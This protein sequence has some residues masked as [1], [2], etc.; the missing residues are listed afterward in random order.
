M[1]VAEGTAKGFGAFRFLVEVMNEFVVQLSVILLSALL[2]GLLSHKLKQPLIVGYLVIGVVLGN[3]LPGSFK[4]SELI[5]FLGELGVAFLLFSLGL[6]FSLK[7]ISV[8]GRT[9]FFGAIL[10]ILLTALLGFFLFP[11]LIGVGSTESIFLAFL[12]AF[13]STA[14]VAKILAEKGALDSLYGELLMGWLVTQDLA[15]LPIMALI[16]LLSGGDVNFKVVAVAVLKPILILYTVLFV[17]KRVLPKMFVKLALLHSRELMVLLGVVFCVVFSYGAYLAGLPFALG[18]FLA[19]VSLSAS[20]INDEV[21]S[22]IKS[23]RDVFAAIFFV[24]LGFLMSI[25][26]LYS[27]ALKIFSLSLVIIL[28]KFAIVFALALY[29]RYHSK[30]AFLVGVGLVQIGEFSFLLGKIGYDTGIMSQASFQ[31]IVSV[32]VITI[33]A[34]PFLLNKAEDFY[35]GIRK[36]SKKRLPRVYNILFVRFDDSLAYAPKRDLKGM[37]NHV[38]LVGYGRVGRSVARA[39]DFSDHKYIVVDLSYGA[40]RFLRNRGVPN[41]FGDA[42]DAEV[43]E[44]ANIGKAAVLILAKPGRHE[45]EYIIRLAR[46]INPNVKVIVRAHSEEEAASFVV[47]GVKFVVEPEFEASVQMAEKALQVLN[48]DDISIVEFLSRLRNEHRY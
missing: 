10:Q 32:A 19:G 41:I 46:R 34:T 37:E 24:S 36:F 22:E 43:L 7:K 48:F 6:E 45:N 21:F 11:V 27:N 26:F 5:L 16:P 23:I 28:V 4:Q 13:S 40:L 38:V 1:R 25:P 18:A 30:V 14:V 2:G 12:V 8:V 33:I 39:L 20:G 17:G 15:V 35:V 42:T 47:G 44:L 31:Y 29:L 9:A 3:V